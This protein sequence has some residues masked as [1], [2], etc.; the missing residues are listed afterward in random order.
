[1]N[2]ES[3]IEAFLDLTAN[4]RACLV[5]RV[6][7]ELTV[8]A[9]RTYGSGG[10]LVAN[11]PMLRAINEIQ[12]KISDFLAR[13]VGDDDTRPPDESFMRWLLYHPNDQLLERMLHTAYGRAVERETSLGNM[14]NPRMF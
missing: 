4:Q 6:I 14:R 1:M 9:R 8:E 2:V 10:K 5:A 7:N 13:L 12:F 11:P 3:E